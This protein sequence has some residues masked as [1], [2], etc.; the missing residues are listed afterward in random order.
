MS[1]VCPLA[2]TIVRQLP[3]LLERL[4]K[5]EEQNGELE[6]R[7]KNLECEIHYMKRKIHVEQEKQRRTR[8][9]M[10]EAEA[11]VPHKQK[12]RPRVDGK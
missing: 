6:L 4:R 2:S 11:E 3:A 1:T 8:K 9:R 10:A 12:K 7:V 5:Y